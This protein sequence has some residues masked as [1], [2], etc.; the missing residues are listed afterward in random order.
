[1]YSECRYFCMYRFCKL[2]LE[3]GLYV[4]KITL[5][6]VVHISADIREMQKYVQ[7]EYV[8]I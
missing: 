4:L 7:H 1:M 8:Y 2:K 5:P 3:W 6:R